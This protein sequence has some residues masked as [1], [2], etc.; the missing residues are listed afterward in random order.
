MDGTTRLTSM[1]GHQLEAAL[2]RPEGIARGGVVVI[3]EVF[4]VTDHIRRVAER[5]AAAGYLAL[6]PAL[7]DRI[8]PGM[9]LEYDEDGITRG[10]EGVARLGW[11]DPLRD[12]RAAADWLAGQ[13]LP[14]AA[15]GFCWGGTLACLCATR[16]G[17]P[18]VAYYGARTAPFLHERPQAP[19]LLHYG[20]HD[21]LFPLAQ[22][23]RVRA[24][25]PAAEIHLYPA[26][27]GFDCDQRAD[28][29]PPSAA[30]AFARSLDFLARVLAR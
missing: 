8:A 13:A 22:V 12:V 30:L 29:H 24:A 16:L 25:W 26:G 14:V 28:F 18:A 9:V 10:R 27:H 2:A 6:V 7:F 19:L 5:F 17:L 23:E 20:E 3:Q 1:D 15:V 21:P 4:G 11:D